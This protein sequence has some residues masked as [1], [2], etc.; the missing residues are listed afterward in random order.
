MWI[1]IGSILGF[2]AVAFGAFGAHALTGKVEDRLIDVWRT[3]ASYQM[4]HALAVLAV[5]IIVLYA[6]QNANLV[7]VEKFAKISGW[8]F[9]VGTMVFSGSLYLMVIS[10]VSA[11]GM[12]TPIGGVSLMAGW[13]CLGYAAILLNK[14]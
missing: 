2:F 3:G 5:G 4:Y 11:L 6:K 10:G 7:E 9:F 8:L 1:M 14:P 12:L 13:L